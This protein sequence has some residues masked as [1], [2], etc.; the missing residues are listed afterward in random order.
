MKLTDLEA[1][2]VRYEHRNE[3]SPCICP[4]G[5]NFGDPYP[6]E[7]RIPVPD[8]AQAQGLWLLCPAC[9]Q[10]NGGAVGTHMVEVTFR[11]RGAQDNQ[12]SQSR[13][14]G[15]SRWAMSGTGL[16]DL[17][18]SPSVDCGCWHGFIGSNG[19]PPGEAR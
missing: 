18:L 7:V 9:F 4:A 15:P 13:N 11:D 8:L 12:G 10:K 1:E 17:S 6:H 5:G 16:H 2:F 3:G 19:V 14:G